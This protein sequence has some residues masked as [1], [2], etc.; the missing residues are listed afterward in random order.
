[1]NSVKMRRNTIWTIIKLSP[2][3]LLKFLKEIINMKSYE[4]NYEN[5]ISQKMRK[6]LFIMDLQSQVFND[7]IEFPIEI[8]I[9]IFSPYMSCWS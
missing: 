7:I 4:K 3:A 8:G 1:M 2:S 9:M 5:G 6:K